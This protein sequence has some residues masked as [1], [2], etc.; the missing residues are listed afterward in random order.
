M[1]KTT[2]NIIKVILTPITYTWLLISVMFM[3]FGDV[4]LGVGDWMNEIVDELKW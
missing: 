4:L 2:E 3:F 1:N